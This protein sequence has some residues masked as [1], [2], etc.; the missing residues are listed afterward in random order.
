[1][2][3]KLKGILQLGIFFGLGFFLVWW[4]I[5]ELTPQDSEHIKQALSRARFWLVVPGIIIIL[6]S[7]YVRT[8]RW[9]LLIEPLGYRPKTLNTF[10]ALMIG[11]LANQAVPRLGEVLRCTFLSRYEKIPFDKLLGTVIL[12]RI[13]DTVSLAAIFALTLVLQSDL[14]EKITSTFFNQTGGDTKSSS[15]LVIGIV[16]GAIAIAILLWMIITKRTVKDVLSFFYK[17][18]QRIWEGISTV[19]HMKKH[20]NFLFLT[21]LLWALYVAGCYIGLL[22]FEETKL[23]GLK[24]SLTVL[25]AGSVGMIATPG[26]IGAYAFLLQ[27][28]MQLYGLNS[29]T[30][31]AFGW[32]LWLMQIVV[33]L[34][35]GAISL[36]LMPIYNRSKFLHSHSS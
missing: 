33:V 6:I 25:S 7:H 10:F 29:G 14:L 19:Q 32:L 21:I 22:A 17:T 8:I 1:M 3:K 27:K 16:V 13:I 11:Y 12:E 9:K 15:L 23:M 20:W 18:L 36:V 34:V 5:K 26:G 2:S 35:V 31:L 28:T 30:A 4:S 24:E